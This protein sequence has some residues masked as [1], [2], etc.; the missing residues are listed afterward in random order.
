MVRSKLNKEA[1]KKV[2]NHYK[3]A[4]SPAHLLARPKNDA[5]FQFISSEKEVELEYAKTMFHKNNL[6]TLILKFY[7]KSFLFKK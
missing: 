4:T 2:D 6:L 1:L 5:D 7:A 3:M